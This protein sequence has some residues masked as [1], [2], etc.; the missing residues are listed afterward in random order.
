MPQ[1]I[2]DNDLPELIN[3]PS[4]RAMKANQLAIKHLGIGVKSVDKPP[5]Q[6]VF[7]RTMFLTLENDRKVVIQFRTEPLDLDAFKIAKEVLGSVVPYA[8]ALRDE[9]LERQRAWASL[10]PRM[11]G[12][13]WFQG[14]AG[15]RAADRI[16]INKSLGRIFSK[17]FLADNSSKAVD[18]LRF[19]L[20]TLLTSQLE[21]IRPHR[22]TIKGFLNNIEEL[23]R[24]PMWI[25]HNDLNEMNVLVDK[26]CTVTA[27]VDWE[28]ST[29]LPFGVGFGR[30]HTL[31]G[32]L[33]KGEFRMPAEFEMA[34]RGFWDELFGGMSKETRK[35]LEEH[36]NLVQ[37]AVILGTLLDC[38]FFQDS[39]DWGCTARLTVLP[40]FLT[41]RIPFVRGNE[42]PYKD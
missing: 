12:E 2:T 38:F 3:T 35:M 4:K 17:G 8:R 13:T 29:P 7:S 33:I 31:A 5:P 14:V 34:E 24:L 22:D 30:I 42:P 40:K 15:R 28:L 18:I 1:I 20:R 21:Q 37:D 10:F 6:G 9:E 27:L 16:A 11:P 41:Y 23:A 39:G 19:R 26:N 32:E 36:I 25:A